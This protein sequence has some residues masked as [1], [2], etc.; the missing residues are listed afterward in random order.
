MVKNNCL[1][2][3]NEGKKEDVEDCIFV[4]KIIKLISLFALNLE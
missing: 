4:N 1:K 3:K 2:F